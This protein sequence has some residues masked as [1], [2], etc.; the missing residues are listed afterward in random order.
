MNYPENLRQKTTTKYD[1]TF[2]GAVRELQI[3]GYSP[4]RKRRYHMLTYTP[5]KKSGIASSTHPSPV[6]WDNVPL[7]S[8]DELADGEFWIPVGFDG[9]K[10]WETE[11]CA[12]HWLKSRSARTRW[13]NKHWHETQWAD[14]GEQAEN[15]SRFV[16]TE[17]KMLKC[18][19]KGSSDVPEKHRKRLRAKLQDLGVIGAEYLAESIEIALKVG[20]V[21][22]YQQIS[23]EELLGYS[24]VSPNV[25]SEI[26]RVVEL[27]YR[28]G[29][30]QATQSAY[31][32]G[33][34]Y[35]AQ[36]GAPTVLNQGKREKVQRGSLSSSDSSAVDY[37]EKNPERKN[38]CLL[39]DFIKGQVIEFKED[40]K[41]YRWKGS[42]K[43][44]TRDAVMKRI[45]DLKARY[46]EKR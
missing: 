11:A 37:M 30:V 19:L 46:L 43:W 44:V 28:A 8:L 39:A 4:I 31:Y 15:P 38:A 23:K 33:V 36:D 14:H 2:E 22:E 1:R 26:L 6:S 29:R 42:T 32:R 13:C 7:D 25:D 45:R 20:G 10:T 34:P 3:Q 35:M 21:P 5:P 24:A 18:D 9:F 16:S 27:A 12:P 41:K 40:S 17:L